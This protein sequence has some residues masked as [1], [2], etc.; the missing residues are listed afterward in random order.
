M[1]E[2]LTDIIIEIKVDFNTGKELGIG[3]VEKTFY[4][5]L[6]DLCHKNE[7]SNPEDKLIGLAKAVKNM[8]D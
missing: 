1:A 5:I 6:K 3:I 2:G 4:D 8:V 7:F